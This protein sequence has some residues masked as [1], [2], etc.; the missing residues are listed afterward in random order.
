MLEIVQCT[1]LKAM[2]ADGFSDPYVK[3]NLGKQRFK[4]KVKYRTLNPVFKESFSLKLNGTDSAV[5]VTVWDRDSYK[6]NDFIGSSKVEL[7]KFEPDRTH[8]VQLRKRFNWN[9]PFETNHLDRTTRI[10]PFK[11]IYV[12]R[13]TNVV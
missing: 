10:E 4:S 1:N 13:T 6:R 7:M 5:N 8:Q 11:L 3:I 9:E 12:D 2:D